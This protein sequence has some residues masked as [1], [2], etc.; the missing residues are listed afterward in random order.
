MYESEMFLPRFR[1]TGHIVSASLVAAILAVIVHGQSQPKQRPVPVAFYTDADGDNI[2]DM[3][4]SDELPDFLRLPP[5]KATPSPPADDEYETG[6]EPHEPDMIAQ[7]EFLVAM[8]SPGFGPW[9]VGNMHRLFVDD[10]YFDDGLADRSAKADRAQADVVDGGP[11]A[12]RV[13]F[14]YRRCEFSMVLVN[15]QRVAIYVSK[16]NGVPTNEFVTTLPLPEIRVEGESCVYCEET[17]KKR[18][19]GSGKQRPGFRRAR[20][21]VQFDEEVVDLVILFLTGMMVVILVYFSYRLMQI[22]FG[23]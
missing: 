15:E 22:D 19:A 5:E 9:M 20:R 12:R 23:S 16:R 13:V 4:D 6:L 10:Y 11:H 14:K 8:Y 18:K 17:Q 3:D 7:Q 21:I 2:W 1:Q